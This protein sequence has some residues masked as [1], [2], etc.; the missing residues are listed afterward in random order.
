MSSFG[1]L[2]IQMLYIHSYIVSKEIFPVLDTL[3]L[4]YVLFNFESS[5]VDPDSLNTDPRF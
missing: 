2:K 5:I 3:L 4:Q 1:N